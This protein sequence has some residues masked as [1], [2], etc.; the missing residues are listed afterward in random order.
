MSAIK[1]S[2]LS[3]CNQE[4][5]G[6]ESVIVFRSKFGNDSSVELSTSK[7]IDNKR[8]FVSRLVLESLPPEVII[9]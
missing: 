8:V 4:L 9:A 6:A 7:V 5:M 2:D 1:L 3:V